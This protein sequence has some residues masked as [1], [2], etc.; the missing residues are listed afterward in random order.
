VIGRWDTVLN[1]L[2]GIND[3]IKQS[4]HME[5]KLDYSFVAG[6]REL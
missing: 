5:I 1:I 6:T 2:S 3:N 4:F